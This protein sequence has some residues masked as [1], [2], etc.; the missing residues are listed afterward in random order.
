[1]KSQAIPFL[2]GHELDSSA[3]VV[4]AKGPG[5]NKVQVSNETQV[6]EIVNL[7]DGKVV[8]E[9]EKHRDESELR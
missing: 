8:H 6:R 4:H 1:M 7:R 3:W 2:V 5:E 9:I